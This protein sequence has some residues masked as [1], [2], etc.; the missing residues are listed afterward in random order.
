[1]AAVA[2]RLDTALS[3]ALI[4][5]G[6]VDPSALEDA[7]Q[8]Q[9]VH[10]GALDTILLELGLLD[11][12]TLAQMLCAAWQTAPV[13]AARIEAPSPEAIKLLPERMAV[14][15]RTCPVFLDRDG[16]HVL[17]PAPLV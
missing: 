13:D 3:R 8:Q 11:E 12:P 15:M 17:V 14:T 4:E 10:G 16:L 1:M 7:V 5:S 2:H 9:L 6:K